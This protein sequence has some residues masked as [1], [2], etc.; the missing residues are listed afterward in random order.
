MLTYLL[1]TTHAARCGSR[2]GLGITLLQYGFYLRAR[3]V[4]LADG[5]LPDDANLLPESDGADTP[6]HMNSLWEQLSKPETT[7]AAKRIVGRGLDFVVRQATTSE[8][9]APTNNT[10]LADALAADDGLMHLPS[11]ESMSA[12]TEWLAYILMGLGWLI[13][14]G[15][16]LSYWKVHRWARQL[17][18]A[19]RRDNQ[20]GSEDEAEPAQS[21]APIG[22]MYTLR[23]ALRNSL[24]NR[25]R[26]RH[27]HS[28]EDWIIFPGRPRRDLSSPQQSPSRRDEDTDLEANQSSPNEQRLI[29][30]MR[31]V[32]LIE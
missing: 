21:D 13:L 18:D 17:V 4:Q 27:A 5:K 9:A 19:A 32:G 3:A 24:Q 12:S 25:R 6:A 7:D 15:S 31:S 29:E 14:L 16:L 8:P 22:F 28:A 1:H 30:D 10:T 11:A 23:N 20:T 2:A 26:A